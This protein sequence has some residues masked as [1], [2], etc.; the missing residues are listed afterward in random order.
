MENYSWWH[1]VIRDYLRSPNKDDYIIAFEIS[2]L[3]YRK[4]AELLS[5]VPC[6]ISDSGAVLD[7]RFHILQL[8]FTK[9][10]VKIK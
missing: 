5:N 7:V 4:V 3:Y 1:F 8:Y 6:Q 9:Y 10:L 2:D